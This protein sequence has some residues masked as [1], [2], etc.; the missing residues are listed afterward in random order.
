[1]DADAVRRGVD[2][3]DREASATVR[4]AIDERRMREPFDG[5]W[6]AAVHRIDFVSEEA[7]KGVAV[8]DAGAGKRPVRRV[9]DHD[10]AVHWIR[11][12]HDADEPLLGT[13]DRTIAPTSCNQAVV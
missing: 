11:G 9:R 2:R 1:K 4:A 12:V 6:T 7:G 10:V 8:A 5:G 3:Y 13:R